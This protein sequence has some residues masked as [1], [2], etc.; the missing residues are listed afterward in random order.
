M[1]TLQ[2]ELG[3]VWYRK[4]G[5]GTVLA[6]VLYIHVNADTKKFRPAAQYVSDVEIRPPVTKAT[7]EDVLPEEPT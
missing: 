3:M 2:L 1:Q 6:R 7:Y 4:S 5:Q